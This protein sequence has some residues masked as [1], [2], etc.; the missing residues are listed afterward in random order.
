MIPVVKY[1]QNMLNNG[2][3][4]MFI[5]TIVNFL[6]ES[7]WNIRLGLRLM[8]EQLRVRISNRRVEGTEEVYI[9]TDRIIT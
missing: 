6:G 3:I 8:A 7:K 9:G 4:K 2:I 5:S 1:L